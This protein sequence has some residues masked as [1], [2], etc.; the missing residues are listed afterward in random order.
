VRT[1]V[2]ARYCG[3]GYP[4]PLVR[5]RVAGL[6]DP[7]AAQARRM[8]DELHR[9]DHDPRMA[10]G[11]VVWIAAVLGFVGCAQ[12]L[13]LVPMPPTTLTPEPIRLK[14]I[15]GVTFVGGNCAL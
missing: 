15:Q 14:L 7:L 9:V 11:P 3:G 13:A 1:F 2:T 10:M 8:G 5:H 12:L 4:P 6:V